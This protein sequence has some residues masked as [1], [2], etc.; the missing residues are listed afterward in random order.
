MLQD[1][2]EQR[3]PTEFAPAERVEAQEI[4]F[5]VEVLRDHPGVSMLDATPDGFVILN[6]KRQIVYANKAMCEMLGRTKETCQPV[7]GQRLGEALNCAHAAEESLYGCGTTQFCSQC[8][9]VKSILTGL[10]GRANTEEC[11]V[12]NVDGDAFDFRVH[13]TPWQFDG[14]DFVM[15][16]VQDI[17][18]E[19]RRR[20]L[21]RIFF[22]DVLNTAGVISTVLD[23]VSNN[24][25]SYD[26]MA[27]DLLFSSGRLIDEI[28]SQQLLSAAE[29]N[30]LSVLPRSILPYELLMNVARATSHY[31]FA[32]EIYLRV[33]AD[34]GFPAIESDQTLLSRVL[35]N[36]AK[37]ALEA[38]S[39]GE[40]V[41]LSVTGEA[42]SVV[43]AVHNA[44]YMPHEVQLQIFK[45]SYSTKGRDRGLGTYSI[46][47]LTER[48][49]GGRAWFETD[50]QRG[51]TFKIA[52]PR[53]LSPE[54]AAGV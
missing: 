25:V 33:D 11:R 39:A 37:N 36:M 1:Q 32:Q 40:T 47:L 23:M 15:F 6:D 30:D 53:V 7:F 52:L 2:I 31:D 17:S 10:R 48:Y 50:S 38:S 18:S 9:A 43:F 29:N 13:S 14:A 5:W 35:V 34:P 4:A 12:T 21:E 42:D 27:D 16:V 24:Y 45:R 49:L 3:L 28:K 51:T 26:E 41:T 8:G 54:A 20:A 44:G 19:K 46:K 22:H